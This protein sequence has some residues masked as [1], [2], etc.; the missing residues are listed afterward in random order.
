MA[1]KIELSYEEARKR[2]EKI[3]AEIDA[4]KI[5]IDELEVTLAEAK[6]LI[7]HALQKLAKAEKIILEWED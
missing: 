5:G 2:L 6:E 4:G 1:K 3:L 7:E